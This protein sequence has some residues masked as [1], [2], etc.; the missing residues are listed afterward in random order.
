MFWRYFLRLSAA[1]TVV[2]VCGFATSIE[3]KNPSFEIPPF[4]AG[5]FGSAVFWTDS[6]PG[7]ITGAFDPS[8]ALYATP[9]PDGEQVAFANNGYMWQQLSDPLLSGY[10]YILR[11]WVGDRLDEPFPGY[12]VELRAGTDPNTSTLLAQDTGGTPNSGEFEKREVTYDS[13]TAAPGDVGQPLMIVLRSSGIQ[14]TYDAVS[15]EALELPEPGSVWMSAS[16]LI[17]VGLL[18]LRK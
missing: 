12:S 3:V 10:A 16:A 7:A 11:F 8:P 6:L 1:M 17:L 5:G 4:G 18:L 14:T 2:S 15:L 9:I 13:R